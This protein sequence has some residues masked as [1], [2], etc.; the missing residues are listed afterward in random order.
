MTEKKWADKTPE[1]TER[2][3]TILLEHHA[4]SPGIVRKVSLEK[5][6]EC[7]IW[8]PFDQLYMESDAQ[9]RERIKQG[10]Q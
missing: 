2:D 6:E 5:T 10:G 8:S 9:L 3:V 7:P 4:K 1:E